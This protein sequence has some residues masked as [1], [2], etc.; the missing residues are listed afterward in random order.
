MKTAGIAGATILTGEFSRE[1]A[2]IAD[3]QKPDES[4]RPYKTELFLDNQMIE[5][6]PGVARRLHSAKK[7][8]L[9]PVVRPARWCEGDY[10]EP[11]TTMYDEDEKLFKMWARAGS[12][13]KS[14]YIGGN[15]ACMVYYTSTDGIHWDKPDLGIIE[16][17]GRRDHNIVFASDLVLK[18]PTSAN[19]GPREF[20]VPTTP[21]TPQGK[22]AFFWS[23][24][25]NPRPRD[26]SEKYI[27][28][29]IV[30]DHRRGAHIVTSPNGLRWSCSPV[31]FWQT[32]HDISS[33][34]D[35]CL[36]HL[37]FDEA[38][39]KWVIYRRIIPEFSERIFEFR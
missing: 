31:P 27:A 38:K 20:I 16:V 24:N 6:S 17:N 18:S 8:L 26:E 30:Q 37:F 15:A 9:N 23:V 12:D 4:Q 3:R 33:K 39:N 10:L 32:P 1:R 19:Y 29:A 7:H 11:Y 36:M 5:A 2:A 34:G 22:K 35:D 28:T 14:G 25:K 13:A 21:M